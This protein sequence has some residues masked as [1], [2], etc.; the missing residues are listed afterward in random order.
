MTTYTCPNGHKISRPEGETV[1]CANCRL[2]ATHLNTRTG[3]VFS[4]T[5]TSEHR[6]ACR[7]LQDQI[8]AAFDNQYFG[9]G[10]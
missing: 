1:E 10:W 2:T 3:E 9:G 5:K 7:N 8:D 6:R 4:W